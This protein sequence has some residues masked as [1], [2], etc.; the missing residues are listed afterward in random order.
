VSPI[1][2][3][4]RSVESAEH[5][6]NGR[7]RRT[8]TK[9]GQELSAEWHSVR[10]LIAPVPTPCGDHRENELP[11]VAEQQLIDARVLLADGLG[12]MGEIE[13]DRPAAARLE[14]DEQRSVRGAE[15]VA[16]V[17]LT[18]KQLFGSP[19]I[20]NRSA[21]PSQRACEHLPVGVDE[22]GREITTRDEILG[23]LNSIREVWRRH[24]ELAH[25]GVQALERVA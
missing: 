24:I 22:L 25:A 21:Q 14:V 23:L 5:L 7:P 4:L 3:K 15:H 2:G 12:D 11:T 16:W 8:R 19:L 10:K 1:G 18:V 13:L 20:A 9:H 17:R 6:V